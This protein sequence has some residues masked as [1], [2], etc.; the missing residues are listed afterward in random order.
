MLIKNKGKIGS[1]LFIWDSPF[2]KNIKKK[3]K[4]FIIKSS[5]SILILPPLILGLKPLGF[6]LFNLLPEQHQNEI[7]GIIADTYIDEIIEL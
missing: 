2:I 5:L 7:K 1:K 3:K 6:K 4:K